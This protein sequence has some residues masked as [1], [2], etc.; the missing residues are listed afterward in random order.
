[1]PWAASAA[2]A[3]PGLGGARQAGGTYVSEQVL[4]L[5]EGQDG[6][7]HGVVRLQALVDGRLAVI[8]PALHLAPAQRSL[9]H[10]LHGTVKHD[11]DVG[12][13]AHLGI[14]RRGWV[15]KRL[16]G[17]VAPCAPTEVGNLGL[18]GLGKKSGPPSPFS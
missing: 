17:T 15:R 11:D 7:A 5:V 18:Y 6:L 1:M 14:H 3:P 10:R 8:C 9:D 4:L 12:G 16:V 13:P 2:P